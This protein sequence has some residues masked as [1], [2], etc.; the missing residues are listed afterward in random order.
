MMIVSNVCMYI[1]LYKI[2][3][4]LP[5]FQY[6]MDACEYEFFVYRFFFWLWNEYV[7]GFVGVIYAR[8]YV[9]SVCVCVCIQSSWLSIFIIWMDM[10][11][12]M[13]G[14]CCCRWMANNK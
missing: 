1:A 8:M 13:D 10:V 11:Q 7:L 9:E 3:I 6:G 14:D 12:Y 2:S 5:S 4:A